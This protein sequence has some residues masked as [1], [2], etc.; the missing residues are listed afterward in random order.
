[1]SS[2]VIEDDYDNVVC[3]QKFG[4]RKLELSSN[5]HRIWAYVVEETSLHNRELISAD[6][7]PVFHMPRAC[8][9]NH[10]LGRTSTRECRLAPQHHNCRRSGG[11]DE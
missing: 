11:W 8:S 7:S 9:E 5:A 3:Q 1:M 2:P 4:R 6:V 10:L